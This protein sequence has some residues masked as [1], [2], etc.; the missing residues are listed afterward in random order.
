MTDDATG[1]PKEH[2]CLFWGLFSCSGCLFI[3]V[4]GIAIFLVSIFGL[5]RS[6]DAYRL[7]ERRATTDPR[8]IAL[9]GS[10]VKS[11][12]LVS[13]NINLRGSTGDADLRFPISGPKGKANVHA[14]ATRANGA[15]TF[16]TLVVHPARGPDIDLLR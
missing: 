7:A 9:L 10:P 12:F 1:K 4:G 16:Q 13:G 11:G 14:V 2:G 15:W 8:V 5:L 6:S 3:A